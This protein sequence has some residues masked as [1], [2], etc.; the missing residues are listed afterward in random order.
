MYI[1][2]I[3]LIENFL[4]HMPASYSLQAKSYRYV[5]LWCPQVNKYTFFN[6]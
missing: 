6:G 3:Y 2:Y 1:L 4:K 5:F